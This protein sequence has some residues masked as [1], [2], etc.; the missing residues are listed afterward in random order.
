V[1]PARPLKTS[2]QRPLPL[3][4]KERRKTRR[5]GDIRARECHLCRHFAPGRSRAHLRAG[6]HRRI[7]RKATQR[8]TAFYPASPID[9]GEV[10]GPDCRMAARA[11]A[12]RTSPRRAP[13]VP[14]SVRAPAL[15]SPFRLCGWNSERRDSAVRAPEVTDARRGRS[16]RRRASSCRLRRDRARPRF[17]CVAS[18]RCWA[19]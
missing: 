14:G 8:L 19:R 4:I 13:V 6:P 1:G 5:L 10:D 2:C 9:A 3:I 16:I 12:G 11:S 7:S 18:S 17:W 15:L